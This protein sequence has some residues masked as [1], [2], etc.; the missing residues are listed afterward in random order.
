MKTMDYDTFT[1]LFKLCRS[2]DPFTMYIDS[3][4]Q[5][6][7]AEKANENIVKKIFNILEEYEIQTN[8]IPYGTTV[9]VSTEE[10]LINLKQWLR[11]KNVTVLEE[12]RRI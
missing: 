6:L 8:I 10:A 2:Y 5:E 9:D 4:R 3:Y 1:K 12:K 11:D 7:Q